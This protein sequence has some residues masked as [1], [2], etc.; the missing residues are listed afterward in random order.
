MA[1]LR[2][3]GGQDDRGGGERGKR[4]ETDNWIS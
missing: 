2:N 4:S 1:R 3:V